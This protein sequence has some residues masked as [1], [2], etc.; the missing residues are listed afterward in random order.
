[1]YKII[2]NV[3]TNWKS[4]IDNE[5][6][7]EY[8]NTIKNNLAN[9]T[10]IVFPKQEDVFNAFNY[11]DI[12]KTNVVILGQ[13]PYINEN[14]AHGLSFSVKNNIPPK[15]LI[16][17][18]K[19]LKNDLNIERTNANLEDW[20]NQGVLLLN[21]ILTVD[22]GAS[23][24]HKNYGWQNFTINVIKHINQNVNHV[25]FVLWGNDAKK[26]KKYITNHNHLIIESSH[27][28]PL[29]AYKGFFD[30]KPFSQINLFLMNKKN[31]NI[32]W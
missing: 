12:K 32:N 13:D 15:S 2:N 28:S 1:M 21:T 17:I 3:K 11:F 30:S 9:N 18:F 5:I 26:Y 20:A 25:A 14:Q 22:K 6:K 7:Q 29:G 4:F 10:N 24:S 23:L 31:Y 8:F 19:E 27:P 16:N